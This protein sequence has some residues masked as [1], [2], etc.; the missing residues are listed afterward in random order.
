MP[1]RACMEEVD[2]GWAVYYTFTGWLA[3]TVAK[4]PRLLHR[5]SLFLD[6]LFSPIYPI[7]ILT[8]FQSVFPSLANLHGTTTQSLQ[9]HSHP[10]IHQLP[11]S[12]SHT[13]HLPPTMPAPVEPTQQAPMD[14]SPADGV[15]NL[16]P[17][18]HPN[19]PDVFCP[20][21]PPYP[22]IMCD[23]GLLTN[24]SPLLQ[25]MEPQPEMGLRGGEEAGCEI[26]CGLCACEESCC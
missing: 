24:P 8:A 11:H 4:K 3:G 7:G 26:C 5:K 15:V 22:S 6:S 10:S 20:P 19:P 12:L 23:P 18:C 2:A 25:S 13:Q 9:N 1:G 14:A 17:V 16:Q 21:L